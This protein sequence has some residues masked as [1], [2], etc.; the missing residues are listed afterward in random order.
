MK[1]KNAFK[2]AL[3]LSLTL[4]LVTLL[5]KNAYAADAVVDIL[6]NDRFNGVVST[7]NKIGRVVDTYFMSFISFVSFF[8]ISAACLRNVLAGAYCVYPKFWDKV[9]EAHKE[10][11]ISQVSISSIKTFFTGGGVQGATVG[12][13]GSFLLSFLPN[14][15]VLTDFDNE[16]DVDFKRYFMKAI[17]QAIIA[18]FI[19]VFIY[20]GYYRD[21]MVKTSQFG[22]EIVVNALN[23]VDPAKT[24]EKLAGVSALPKTPIDNAKTG[25]EAIAKMMLQ[26]SWAPILGEY[27]DISEKSVKK[28]NYNKLASLLVSKAQA[29]SAF[30]VESHK[31]S[32]SA[33]VEQTLIPTQD[34]DLADG[35][36]HY[37]YLNIPISEIGLTTNEHKGDTMYLRLVLQIVNT[38]KDSSMSDSISDFKLTIKGAGQNQGGNIGNAKAKVENGKLVVQGTYTPSSGQAQSVTGFSIQDTS[39]NSVHT[40][41]Q[42]VF[43]GGNG[44]AT[45]EGTYN[46]KTIQATWGTDSISSKINAAKSS[47]QQ[48]AGASQAQQGGNRPATQQGGNNNNGDDDDLSGY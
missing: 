45:L 38:I 21:V 3:T 1:R 23:S 31:Y 32:I 41:T 42:I 44:N 15:K 40:I 47:A 12:S 22:S 5:H 17:P 18:V 25:P 8:I 29:F 27:P 13:V 26:K 43:T 14:L 30:P 28:T 11:G 7:V 10:K 9:D 46:G 34:T 2:V 16:N 20:N 39:S 24:M 36:T 48:G 37:R 35:K 19:G 33:T 6:E 4:G